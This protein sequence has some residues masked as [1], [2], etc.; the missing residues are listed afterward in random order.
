MEQLNLLK[1]LVVVFAVAVFVVAVLHR[2][3]IPNIA[4]FIISG[5]IV[6][7]DILGLVGDPHDVEMLAE[8]G[9]ALLLFGIGLEISL[10][11]L[12]RLWWPI[13]TGGFLQ[14]G[15]TT[16]ATFG[17]CLL[18]GMS[19]ASSIFIGFLVSLS[20]TAIVLRGLD[21][22][23]EIDAPH[24]RLTLG[25]LVFQDLAVVPMMLLIPFLAST[26]EGGNIIIALLKSVL[27]IAAVLVAARIVLPWVLQFIARTRQRNLFV[28][29]VLL[30]CM[31][32]AWMISASGVSLALGA[33]L[34][35]IVVAS[36]EY[37]HQA[38]ADL[39]PFRDVFTSLFF[40]SVGMLLD[41]E[42]VLSYV[43]QVLML[44]GFIMVGKFL[45][46]LFTGFAMRLPIAIGA[47][48]AVSLTQVGEFSLVLKR[49][50][51]GTG[52]L[53]EPL[54]GNLLTA[55]ILSML[56]TPF[57]HLAAPS[58][59]AGVGRIKT[60]MRFLDV[61]S[62]DEA[63]RTDKPLTNHVIIGGYGFAGAELARSLDECGVP[64]VI[65][66]LNIDNVKRAFAEGRRVYFGDITSPEVLHKLGIE[67]AK[68]FVVVINN[69]AALEKAIMSARDIA[70]N[71]Y[72][73][74][75]TRYLLDTEPL[76]NAGAN[77]VIPAEREAAVE[78]ASVILN[79]YCIDSEKLK[80]QLNRIRDISEEESP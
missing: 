11:K 31:G 79:R 42:Q 17:I 51:D 34:A 75:R 70:P 5:I 58:I 30:I 25:I 23:G 65:C 18:F 13:L 46:V 54:A 12:K 52:L 38:L 63:E 39:I 41:T 60:L 45:I 49:A 22:R 74:A 26:G 1:D 69:P 76:L 27:I 15:L 28:L 10:D 67:R 53:S 61:E 32:T 33:F 14:V 36:S 2:A 43:P 66:E 44:L 62:A 7:P 21:E 77:D 20:S 35:G 71:L 55:A 78:V 68:E 80:G 9:V 24:G 29:T 16:M 48:A 6:G 72:I 4:G 19:P 57:L 47:L 50:A 64:Y 8:I 73:I 59:A 56:I 40:V 3:G 37:R